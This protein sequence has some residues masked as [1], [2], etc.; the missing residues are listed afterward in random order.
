MEDERAKLKEQT[1][2][3]WYTCF[4]I[5]VFC[6]HDHNFFFFFFFFFF[7][8]SIYPNRRELLVHKRER[9]E[10]IDELQDIKRMGFPMAP[11]PSG[12]SADDVD[13]DLKKLGITL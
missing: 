2:G 6:L 9:K 12:L 10:E 11:D 5:C 8:D 3:M 7:L 13:E 1:Q 4:Y